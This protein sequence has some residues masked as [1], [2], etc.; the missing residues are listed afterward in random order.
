MADDDVEYWDSTKTYKLGDKV[1]G[2]LNP[3]FLAPPPYERNLYTYVLRKEVDS[4]GDPQL[5]YY[6]SVFPD[7]PAYEEY[8]KTLAWELLWPEWSM[9]G[10]YGEGSLVVYKGRYYAGSPRMYF[11]FEDLSAPPRRLANQ[12][13][14]VLVDEQGVRAWILGR[15]Q[16]TFPTYALKPYHLERIGNFDDVSTHKREFAPYWLGSNYSWLDGVRIPGIPEGFSLTVYQGSPAYGDEPATSPSSE[17]VCGA[18]FQSLQLSGIRH[19]CY[20]LSLGLKKGENPVETGGYA[21][22]W[23][24]TGDRTASP[25]YNN[26]ADPE[27]GEVI[28]PFDQGWNAQ[29]NDCSTLQRGSPGVIST[30]KDNSIGEV[31]YNHNHPLYFNRK[32]A[33]RAGTSSQ[34]SYWKFYPQTLKWDYVDGYGQPVPKPCW[35]DWGNYSYSSEG[36]KYAIK[37]GT[38]A[39]KEDCWSLGAISQYPKLNSIGTF[40]LPTGDDMV[41]GPNSSFSQ[42]IPLIEAKVES[43]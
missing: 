38:F 24:Y 3:E 7:D 6:L 13:P 5:Q 19:W 32:V 17:L 14:N 33:V 36:V 39:P 41:S 29:D 43:N 20:I 37:S 2:Y 18:A 42:N 11:N 28:P 9:E 22:P 15:P 30:Q 16:T 10:K 31:Y 40:T 26:W 4:P 35:W 8:I 21:E 1:R 34:K 12:P 23:Y 25:D 27:T